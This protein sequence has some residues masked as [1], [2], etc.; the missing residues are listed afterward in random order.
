MNKK[1]NKTIVRIMMMA[2]LVTG[3][4]FVSPNPAM[5]GDAFFLVIKNGSKT[6]SVTITFRSGSCYQGGTP[7]GANFDLAPGKSDRIHVQ[8]DEDSSCTGHW[9]YFHLTLSPTAEGNSKKDFYFSNDGGLDLVNIAYPYPGKLIRPDIKFCSREIDC[10]PTRDYLFITAEKP[11]ELTADP[12]EGFWRLLC[13]ESCNDSITNQVTNEKTNERT[14]SEEVKWSISVALE[15]GFKS[16]TGSFKGTVTGGWE[17]TTATSMSQRIMESTSKTTAKT[18]V[19]T[20]GEMRDLNI[21]AVWQWRAKTALSNGQSYIIETEQITCT[22]D[23]VTPNYF[24]GSREHIGTCRGKLGKFN[25]DPKLANPNSERHEVDVE[26]TTSYSPIWNDKGSGA[27]SPVSFWRPNITSGWSRVGH[28]ISKGY[29]NPQGSTMLVRP[30]TNGA[31]AD[32]SD[33]TLIWNDKGSE[34]SQDGSVWRAV[35][36]NGYQALGDVTSSSHAKPATTEMVCVHESALV[37]ANVGNA[38]W[39]DSGSGAKMDFASWEI[40]PSNGNQSR[41]L[42]FGSDSYSLAQIILWAVR[43]NGVQK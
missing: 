38:I 10:V 19:Y 31:I 40:S 6:R 30:R 18:I 17:K 35:C 39:S 22:S 25:D 13:V 36:K 1:S 11:D 24:P 42:F 32:P 43:S 34:A 27:S 29:G 37:N 2:V 9:G 41:G 7:N 28:H 8:R 4:F 5:A 23:Q 16:P 14:E 26:F 3:L 20:P 21:H 15:K 33:Y 12:P